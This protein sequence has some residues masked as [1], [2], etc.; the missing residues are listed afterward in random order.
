M[1]HVGACGG[2]AQA[3]GDVT[4]AGERRGA[5][6]DGGSRRGTA[7]REARREES[8]AQGGDLH[9]KPDQRI[10]W[11]HPRASAP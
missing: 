10:F 11:V 7:H 1:W 9:E 8:T 6:G 2:C 5:Q 4:G 3:A